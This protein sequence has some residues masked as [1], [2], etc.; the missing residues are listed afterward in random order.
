[1]KLSD[2]KWEMDPVKSTTTSSN[3]P[4]SA[5]RPAGTVGTA[6]TSTTANSGP[7]QF[8]PDHAV[9]ANATK[10]QLKAMPQFDTTK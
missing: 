7:K 8:W 9:M 3:T 4:P 5:N 6:S 10:D 2:L 1:M